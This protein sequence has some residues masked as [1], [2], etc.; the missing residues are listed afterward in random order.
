VFVLEN[1]Y[2]N[3]CPTPKVLAYRIGHL[4]PSECFSVTAANVAKGLTVRVDPP[5][6]VHDRDTVSLEMKIR[7]M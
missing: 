6:Y 1:D 3:V 4:V 5:G 2:R 7:I